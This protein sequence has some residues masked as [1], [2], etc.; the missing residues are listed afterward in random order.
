[1]SGTGAEGDWGQLRGCPRGFVPTV[2]L[3]LD[4]VGS[5]RGR[6]WC[7]GAPGA[8]STLPAAGQDRAVPLRPGVGEGLQP[9]SQTVA[10]IPWATS[11]PATVGE[12]S[13]ERVS[14]AVVAG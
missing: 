11:A 3:S 14:M 13:K 1:M 4:L 8:R 2:G 6:A 9:R 7:L 12:H 10:T 5:V